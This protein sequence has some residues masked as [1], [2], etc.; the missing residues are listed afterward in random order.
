MQPGGPF[1]S[2][3]TGIEWM[4]SESES[5]VLDVTVKRLAKKSIIVW[6]WMR[7]EVGEDR[8]IVKQWV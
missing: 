1:K 4:G 3:S 6:V 5:E 8:E 7:C 2:V